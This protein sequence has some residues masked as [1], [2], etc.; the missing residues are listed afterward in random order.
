MILVKNYVSSS[1]IHGLGMFAAERIPTGTKF[2]EYLPGVD[3]SYS[4]DEFQELPEIA[5]LFIRHYG[6]LDKMSH[7]WMLGFDND[8]YM[9]HSEDPHVRE[10]AGQV[11]V[12]REIQPNEEITCNYREFDGD[13]E[14]KLRSV[15][16]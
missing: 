5:Q 6:Y 9:N 16:R 7:R 10:V 4:Q 15:I 2:W 1:G 13:W 12:V 11:V 8:R 3:L 14:Y